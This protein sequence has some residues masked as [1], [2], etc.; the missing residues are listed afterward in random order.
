MR[1]FPE[2]E[3]RR[4]LPVLGAVTVLAIIAV[5]AVPGL[6]HSLLR[7][8][9]HALVAQDAP[10][11]ADVIIVSTDVMGAGL[12]ESAD[13]V[14]AGVAPRVAIFDRPPNRVQ[15][16]FERRGIKSID[17]NQVSVQLL[18]QLGLTDVLVIPAVVGTEDEGKVL[19]RWCAANSIHSIV[20]VSTPDHSRRTRRV[21]N[22]SLRP[23][24]VAVTV[25]YSKYS[26]FDPDSWW[27]SREGQRTEAV[28]MEKL[29]LDLLRHP[30]S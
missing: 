11:R 19:Q 18:R 27:L 6:R 21:L 26:D 30:F 29:L 28:E 7:S 22:R 24:G 13:L 16:E 10:T 3:P 8:A 5:L 14:N 12:L 17:Y 25:K 4:R 1:P 2:F 23:D 20:F 15:L 9:G